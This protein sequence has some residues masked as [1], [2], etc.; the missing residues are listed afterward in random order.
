MNVRHHL[1][2]AARA[3]LVLGL[4]ALG[5]VCLG[6]PACGADA[7]GAGVITRGGVRLYPKQRRIEMDGKFCLT[8][9]PIELFAC[10]RG[11]KEYE[12][13]ISLR[14]KPSVLHLFLVMM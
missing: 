11:G 10:A 14:V 2:Y 6:R 4:A 7:G 9:G 8:E 12:S 1:L 5:S 3:G 13:V